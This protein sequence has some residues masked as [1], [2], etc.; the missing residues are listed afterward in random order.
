MNEKN[1]S[2]LPIILFWIIPAVG[3]DVVEALSHHENLS[4]AGSLLASL[5]L[6][7]VLMTIWVYCGWSA[8][9]VGAEYQH[10]KLLSAFAKRGWY[11]V[12]DG[13]DYLMLPA[14]EIKHEII[15]QRGKE[16]EQFATVGNPR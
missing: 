15:A 7:I 10:M 3:N 16:P 2:R 4:V 12:V 9:R 5:F 13:E 1:F 6:T 8:W 14:D 11:A